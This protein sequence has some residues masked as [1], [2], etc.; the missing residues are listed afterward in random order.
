MTLPT[1]TG[2]FRVV[3]DPELRFSPGGTAV[4]NIRLVANSRKKVND[5]W[6]DDKVVWLRAVA[7]KTMAENIA[8]S[9]EKG[10]LVTV[11]GRLQ[12]E[13]YES[14]GEKRQAYTV[15]IDTIGPSLAFR[16]A[17]VAASNTGA[18][19][20]GGGGG[21]QQ[22]SSQSSGDGGDPWASPSSSTDEPPF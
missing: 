21:Q 2:E 20:G 10:H 1:I 13:E 17:K 14:N 6:V 8:E 11:T 9:I 16:S 12:T 15:L 19:T 7:F 22:Q 18:R 3:A 4:A 5:E